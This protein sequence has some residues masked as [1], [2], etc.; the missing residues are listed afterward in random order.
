MTHNYNT[1]ST[2]AAQSTDLSTPKIVFK[3]VYDTGRIKIFK[4]GSE[5]DDFVDLDFDIIDRVEMSGKGAPTKIKN[6]MV[7]D[8]V[9]TDAECVSLTS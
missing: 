3:R 1:G 7:F 5:I 9:L 6:V 8:R 2:P 4:N